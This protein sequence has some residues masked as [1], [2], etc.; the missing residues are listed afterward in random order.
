MLKMEVLR[1]LIQRF[2]RGNVK[3][4]QQHARHA[5]DAICWYEGI[6]CDFPNRL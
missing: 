5:D 4:P 3:G 2:R 6:V 1:P